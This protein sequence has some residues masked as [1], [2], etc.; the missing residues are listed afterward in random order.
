VSSSSHESNGALLLD[1][2][3]LAAE[4]ARGRVVVCGSHGG[5]YSGRVAA[6]HQVAAVIFNDA[7]IGRDGAGIAGLRLLD[8]V[9]TP[10]AVV[11]HAGA[12]IGD[13]QDSFRRGVLSVINGAADQAGWHAGLAVADAVAM[14]AGWPA[15][16]PHA[17][18]DVHEGR[19][20]L[21]AGEVDV[22]ALDSA[23]LARSADAGAVLA[24]GSHGGLVGGRE[25]AALRVDARA[26][27]FN[28]AGGGAGTTRLGALDRRG[29]AAA[30]VSADSAR[31]GDGRSTYHDGVVSA[32]NRV[33]ATLGAAPGLTARAFTDLVVTAARNG[34]AAR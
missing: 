2:I 26:A 18:R 10:A 28:D 14:A 31:I 29:I 9:G 13:A 16:T 23:S 25:D 1:S 19:Y 12:R 34:G 33:A 3:T 32:V 5:E 15:P 24:T 30:T 21:A 17:L 11:G 22:W 8:E 20:L 4:G 27:L 6:E 7:G